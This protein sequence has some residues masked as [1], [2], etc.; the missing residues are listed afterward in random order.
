MQLMWH[1]KEV[2]N[3]TSV[4]ESAAKTGTTAESSTISKQEMSRY[5]SVKQTVGYRELAV[6][7][8]RL[9]IMLQFID[10]KDGAVIWA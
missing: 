4:E 5:N 7:P 3:K 1:V 6:S 2:A 10:G 9:G 8:G